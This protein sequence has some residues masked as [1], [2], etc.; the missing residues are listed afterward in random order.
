[1]L[2][3][4]YNYINYLLYFY[5]PR[6]LLPAMASQVVFFELPYCS[7]RRLSTQT[8]IKMKYLPYLLLLL[9]LAGFSLPAFSSAQQG[10]WR[11]RNDDG[12]EIS[13][14]WMADP[15]TP[16]VLT[17]KD[18]IRLRIEMANVDISFPPEPGAVELRYSYDD[19]NSWQKVEG[20][21]ST[22]HFV[23]A[24][25]SYFS[26]Q[27]PSTKQLTSAYGY[28]DHYVEGFLF[29]THDP[30]NMHPR[31]A[32][33]TTELEFCIKATGIAA[34]ATTYHF[35]FFYGEGANPDGY[36]ALLFTNFNGFAKIPL[37][38]WGI[39]L[40]ALLILFGGLVL[41]RRMF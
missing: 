19:E 11:W 23:F 31:L 32:G 13:A 25:S 40:T 18:N 41:K 15:D 6:W 28:D 17:H 33:E 39:A 7:N 26:N 10:T 36:A 1:L 14:T 9:L 20:D 12:G 22:G 37:S 8:T 21:E 2:N 29:D 3:I 35:K 38:R 4:K 27:S 30:T 5:R 24:N 16:I 34:D